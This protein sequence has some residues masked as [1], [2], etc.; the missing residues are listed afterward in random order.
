MLRKFTLRVTSSFIAYKKMSISIN[1]S[2]P[3]LKQEKK[4]RNYERLQITQIIRTF[5]QYLLRASLLVEK[6]RSSNLCNTESTRKL[7]NTSLASGNIFQFVSGWCK[8]YSL[9]G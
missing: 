4:N 3:L 9:Q 5:L 2:K 1:I 8:I 7:N 6:C